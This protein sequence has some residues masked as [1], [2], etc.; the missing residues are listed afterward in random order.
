MKRGM[1]YPIENFKII[2]DSRASIVLYRFLI[3][4]K[5]KGRIVLPIN[6]CPVVVEVIIKAGFTVLFVDI[7]DENL[8]LDIKK[9]I[10]LLNSDKSIRGVL[11]NHTYGIEYDFSENVES[12][13]NWD[14]FVIEDKCLCRPVFVANYNVDLTL[15]STGYAKFV[16]L[17]YAGGIGLSKPKYNFDVVPHE[18]L[19]ENNKSIRFNDFNVNFNK[20]ITD[21]NT[22]LEL[23][24]LHKKQI[25]QVYIDGLSDI[26][27]DNRFNNWRYNIVVKDKERT[28]SEIFNNNLFVSSHYKPL[29]DNYQDYAISW[30]LFNKVINL[31]NDKYFDVNMAQRLVEIIRS[32]NN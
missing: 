13:K 26:S 10:K 8:C 4:R 12:I 32:L 18:L 27:L 9:T 1:D 16:E 11:I 25:N 31:F 20:Y 30:N 14:V 6:I 5:D 7:S 24:S 23:I 29:S 22:G 19:L 21:I 28:I 2:T 3:N 17:N 15:F